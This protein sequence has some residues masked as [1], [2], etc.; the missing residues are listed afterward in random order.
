MTIKC[1]SEDTAARLEGGRLCSGHSLLAIFELIP[2]ADTTGKDT[3]AEIRVDY[4]L[5][6]K[7]P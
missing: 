2:Q 3:L 7:R 6:E 1:L 4:S 5:P